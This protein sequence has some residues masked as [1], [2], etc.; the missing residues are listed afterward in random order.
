VK[1]DERS[2]S[3]ILSRA[4]RPQAGGWSPAAAHSLL[5]IRL[6]DEDLARADELA[7]KAAEGILSDREAHELDDYRH[8]GRLLEMLKAKARISLKQVGAA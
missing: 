4:I 2:E 3:A 5:E 7:C 6:T 1:P 8:A